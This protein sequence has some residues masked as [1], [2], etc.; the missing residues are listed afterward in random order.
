MM[1]KTNTNK[2]ISA[3]IVGIL[4]ALLSFFL[5][6]SHVLDYVA[7]LENGDKKDDSLFLF[8]NLFLNWLFPISTSIFIYYQDRFPHIIYRYTLYVLGFIYAGWG[9][10]ITLMFFVGYNYYYFFGGHFMNVFIN[11]NTPFEVSVLILSHL[12]YFIIGI[13]LI[14][15]IHKMK[16]NKHPDL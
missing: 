1:T 12:L 9:G 11:S 15:F 16:S 10:L 7:R 13:F 2:Y 14:S 8:Y 5:G 4:F 3:S 6:F